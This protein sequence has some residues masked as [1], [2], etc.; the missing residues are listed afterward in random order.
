M[1]KSS[2]DSQQKA[3]PSNAPRLTDA[4]QS[5]LLDTPF[6]T[7]ATC[8]MLVIRQV[9]H[10]EGGA[11]DGPYWQPCATVTAVLGVAHHHD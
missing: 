9:Y 11:S 1:P 6:T 8:G 3:K 2:P 5:A 10:F 7:C 4:E